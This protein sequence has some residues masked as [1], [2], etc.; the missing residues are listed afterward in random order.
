M[1]EASRFS[2]PKPLN[3]GLICFIV[4]SFA[5]MAVM[6]ATGEFRHY[7][8]GLFVAVPVGMGLLL[9][10]LYQHGR[11]WSWVGMMGLSFWSLV[12]SALWLL[13]CKLEGYVCILM[14]AVLVS[15][16]MLVGI[17][18]AWLLQAWVRSRER[19]QR[20]HCVAILCVPV[21]MNWEAKAPPSP[22][23][24]V[25]TS[26]IVVDA[27]PDVVWKFIPSFPAI[28]SPPSGWLASGVAYPI[29]SELEGSG[30]GAT[31]RCVLSTGSMPEVVTVWEPPLR[32]EFDVIETPA[33]MV[34]SNPFGEVE[35]PHVDG[36]FQAKRGRFLLR[37]LPGGKTEIEGTSWFLNKLW[38]Q[39][40]WETVTRHTV[41][42]IH[43]RVLQHIKRLAEVAE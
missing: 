21:L 3:S 42:Q 40:Y 23:L 36:Y 17:F 1:S 7:G 10:V 26:R 14:A 28:E 31:R 29:A 20:I 13:V 35:A 39:W 18:V 30:V 15:A 12:L 25:Q 32:L 41:S 19:R 24:M 6:F 34:E 27:P 2:H 16:M 33:A 9:A 4:S 22:P 38:P 37:S 43:G 5:A 8:Y 11:S